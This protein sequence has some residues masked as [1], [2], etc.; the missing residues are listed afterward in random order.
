VIYLGYALLGVAAI[1]IVYKIRVSY[2][3]AG[4]TDFEVPVYDAALYPPVLA[5][6]GLFLVLR[7]HEIAWPVWGYL[8]VWLGLTGLVAAA[9]RG[10]EELGDRP[11]D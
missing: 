7:A 11:L 1:W 10:F 2:N 8:L 5:V 6:V 9:I 3:S 4:G